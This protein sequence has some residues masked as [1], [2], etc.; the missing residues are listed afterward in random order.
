MTPDVQL[1]DAL[2]AGDEAAFVEVVT[3]YHATF[4]RIAKV[5]VRDASAA[6][7]IVQQT[8]LI[9]LE[10][11]ERFEARSTLRTWLYGIVVNT[12]RAHAR[13]IA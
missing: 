3:R 7:E 5:W 12:A 2:R 4:A 9:M 10:S 6:E 11:L 1:I 8:W 13:A